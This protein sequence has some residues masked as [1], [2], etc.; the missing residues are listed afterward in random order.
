MK[1]NLFLFTALIVCILHCC[2]A[3]ADGFNAIIESKQAKPGETV[4]INVNFENNSGILA[5]IFN[6]EYDKERLE[7][8]AVQDGKLLKGGI[9]SPDYSVYPYKMVWNSASSENFTADGT[10]VT[11]KFKVLDNAAPGSAFIRLSYSPDDVFDVDFN[12]I[13]LNIT[14]GGIEVLS[15]TPQTGGSVNSGG[16]YGGGY[17][18]RPS[19]SSGSSI[20]AQK[21]NEKNSI[22]LTI[23]KT[24]ALVFGELKS[25]DVAPVVRNDRTMLP[26]RFVAENL[27]AEVLWNNDTKQVIITKENITIVIT[28][29][30]KN[31]LVNGKTVE[32]DSPAFVEND[33]TYTPLRFIAEELGA[34]VYWDGDAQKVTITK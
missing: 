11:L 15:E 28:I 2:T 21:L 16:S 8:T 12:N 30:E 18:S 4:E 20:P 10:L 25:N 1:K 32:L 33:R 27:G 26:A 7:L 34:K 13:P 14:N 29:A 19:Y 31:A 17:T 24:E 6:A 23:G 9:F 3:F 5:A 22:I